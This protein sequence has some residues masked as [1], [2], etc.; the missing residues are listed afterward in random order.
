MKNTLEIDLADQEGVAGIESVLADE[1][2]FYILANK[3]EHKLGY[4]L[5][6]VNQNDPEGVKD[7]PP[8]RSELKYLI[9]WNN[10]L[11]IGNCTMHVM[12]ENGETSI[13]VCYKCIG[14]NTFNVFVIDL[15]T[16]LIK[17]WHESN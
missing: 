7:A 9:N 10:K 17:Y 16:R 6:T 4:Y 2:D 13:V 11:D 14:I 8:P 3:R 1:T 5:F 12:K 15:G